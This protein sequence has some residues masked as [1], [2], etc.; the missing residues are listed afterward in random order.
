M[1]LQIYSQNMEVLW[2][3]FKDISYNKAKNFHIRSTCTLVQHSLPRVSAADYDL[4][5]ATP[6][7]KTWT[8]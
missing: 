7:F 6:I 2:L 3:T 4:Q 8:I 1:L 5:G